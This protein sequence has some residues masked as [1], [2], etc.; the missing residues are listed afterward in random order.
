M[1]TNYG[2]M[3]FPNNG[4]RGGF[5]PQFS[6]GRRGNMGAG[7]FGRGGGNGFNNLCGFDG[8]AMNQMNRP[9]NGNFGNNMNMNHIH[10][11]IQMDLN[12]FDMMDFN[13]MGRGGQNAPFGRGRGCSNQLN[14]FGLRKPPITSIRGRRKQTQKDTPNV[15][16]GKR[17]KIEKDQ[18]NEAVKQ[19]ESSIATTS[20]KGPKSVEVLEKPEEN[21][22]SDSNEPPTTQALEEDTYPYPHRTAED[23]LTKQLKMSHPTG[24]VK[25][26][27]N[28][29]QWV[30]QEKESTS[31]LQNNRSF[32]FTVT[33][34]GVVTKGM[35]KKKKDA[36]N[37]AYHA[38][39][40]KFGEV[41]RLLSPQQGTDR[42]ELNCQIEKLLKKPKNSTATESLPKFSTLPSQITSGS[43]SSLPSSSPKLEVPKQKLE[44]TQPKLTKKIPASISANPPGSNITCK[45]DIPCD[46]KEFSQQEIQSIPGHPVVALGDILK[47]LK[48]GAPVFLCVKEERMSKIGIYCKW[49]FTMR[50]ST[51][52]GKESKEFYGKATT[53][54]GAKNQAAAAAYFALSGLVPAPAKKVSSTPE[55]SSP[56]G[57]RKIS[58][59]GS[60]VPLPV[61]SSYLRYPNCNMYAAPKPA[62][63]INPNFVPKLHEESSSLPPTPSYVQPQQ[64]VK[65][66]PKRDQIPN[67]NVSTTTG[68]KTNLLKRESLKTE[69]SPLKD[70][71]D[72]SLDDC[73]N[74]FENFL[75]GLDDK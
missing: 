8:S 72:E 5:S 20:S 38:M 48:Y 32:H 21:S 35:A 55:P 75:S 57:G 22:V 47:S 43:T 36:K 18:T 10:Q 1:N 12:E 27:A 65:E 17:M 58:V 51:T 42:Q 60:A 49:M 19:N 70:D 66:E 54:K 14:N 71:K 39:A 25:E 33:V 69:G 23:F 62:I 30:V 59:I 40:L 68:S 34:E 56:P 29:R 31:G 45:V 41:F 9:R 53:K 2:N 3:H 24:W 16:H 11:Q 64:K 50:V 7:G 52:R 28:K 46:I 44:T 73:L 4:F 63:H 37:K 6:R 61:P 15:N 74:E 67:V 13:M 26:A